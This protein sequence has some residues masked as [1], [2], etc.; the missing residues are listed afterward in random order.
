MWVPVRIKQILI[1][2][3]FTKTN[4]D[5]EISKFHVKPLSDEQNLI[6]FYENQM[7]DRCL[8]G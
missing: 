6:F 8:Q 7:T 1:N 2:N 5:R 4:V 3:G